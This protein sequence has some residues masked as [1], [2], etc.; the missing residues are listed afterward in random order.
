MS[1]LVPIEKRHI[2]VTGASSGI[3]RAIALELAR[4]PGARLTLLARRKPL[5]EEVAKMVGVPTIS[6]AHDFS[7]PAHATDW[8]AGAEAANGPIDILVNNAGVQVIGPTHTLDLEAAEA[9][10]RTNLVSPLRLTRAV[11]PGM[12]ARRSGTIVDIASMAALAPTPGM[13]WYNA[14]KAGLA[15]ASEALHGELRGTG[16]HVVTVYPG[17]IA[18][19][20][21]DAATSKYESSAI[22]RAQ[23]V[24][25]AEQLAKAIRNAIEKKHERLI[26]PRFNAVARWFPAQTRWLMDRFTP[27]FRKTP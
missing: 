23:P 5:L 27:A 7:D 15:A 24:A 22:L 12:L 11:L 6:I 19:G 4:M 17:I 8:I 25:T 20:M 3:G 13:T 16:V 10:L 26:Y 14:S 21:A 2:A 18:T 1:D 9:S